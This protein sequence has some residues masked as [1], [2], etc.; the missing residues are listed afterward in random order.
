MSPKGSPAVSDEPQP[1]AVPGLVIEVSGATAVLTLER[2][3]RHNA[4]DRA[5]RA[6]IAES[7]PALARDPGIYGLVIRSG[8]AGI[9]SAGGDVRELVADARDRPA[10]ACRALAEEYAL[11]WLL[12]CFSKPTVSLIDG[13]VMGAGVGL[14]QFGT[15]RV[16]G[17]RYR[18]QMPE[19]AIG[20]FPD[21]GIA[22]VFARLPRRIGIYLGL[23]G[24]PVTRADAFRLRL[25]THCIPAAQFAEIEAAFADAQPIDPVLDQRHQ[26]PGTGELEALSDAIERCFAAATLEEIV[27]RLEQE[28]DQ[29]AWARG[30]LADLAARSPL[31]LKTTLRHI[32]EAGALDLRQTLQIDYRLASRLVTG[33]DFAEGV[34]AHVIDKDRKPVWTPARMEDVS[35][36]MVERLRAPMPGRELVLPTRQ[37]M[38]AMRV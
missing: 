12:E 23:T 3:A 11:I 27:A 10:E 9:F 1:P 33:A 16:A 22:H 21:D 7:I 29:A 4:V 32:R 28:R 20:F 15:H 26:D 18:F 5:M 31:A 38:Q 24:R 8:A 35:P 37:E 25:A 13:A 36:A 34:R 6:R 2:P 14:T 19:T 17:E 30:V